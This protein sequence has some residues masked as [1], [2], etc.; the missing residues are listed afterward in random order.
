MA[1]S[2]RIIL[3]INALILLDKFLAIFA[4]PINVTGY[5]N[6][7]NF[8][9]NLVDQMHPSLSLY[10][11]RNV[12]LVSNRRGDIESA[13]Y[14]NG[15]YVQIPSSSVSWIGDFSIATWVFVKTRVA[16]G[17]L[18]DCGIKG[19]NELVINL[20][21][22]N[23]DGLAFQ[24]YT[25][26]NVSSLVYN[27]NRLVINKWHHVAF[28]F[29]RGKIVI[30]TDGA[31]VAS[32]TTN[33]K[34]NVSANYGTCFIGK[35]LWNNHN[36][37][38]YIDD[39]WLF[40]RGLSSDEVQIVMNTSKLTWTTTTSNLVKDSSIILPRGPVANWEFNNNFIDS[41][42]KTLFWTLANGYVS[43]TFPV[44]RKWQTSSALQIT[45][46]V[47]NITK[48]PTI[49][50]TH[51]TLMFWFYPQKLTDQT[52]FG[53]YNYDYQFR[54]DITAYLIIDNITLSVFYFPLNDWVH[55]ATT[56]DAS[57]SSMYVNGQSMPMKS[58]YVSSATIIGGCHFGSSSSFFGGLDDVMFFQT[59]LTASEIEV[60]VEV[61]QFL[62]KTGRPRCSF[63]MGSEGEIIN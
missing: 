55:L 7:W 44:D 1:K 49:Y 31:P 24:V 23:G 54:S 51:N 8:E 35:S 16:C 36:I 57:G 50:L 25:N 32:G 58:N 10:N 46:G 19:Q 39:L 37:N 33:I 34:P 43:S 63:E 5:I 52:I 40:N 56:Q 2:W 14:L 9:K 47:M 17:K 20:N 11:S 29:N 45:G 59:V 62:G 18:L 42:T 21:S 38:A 60:Y 61:R 4:Q 53:F 15:G 41:V 27:R 6:Y 12:S 28:T 22:C 26:R 3:Y 13:L 30:Y 48:C